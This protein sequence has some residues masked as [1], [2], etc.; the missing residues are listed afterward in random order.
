MSKTNEFDSEYSNVKY[1]EADNI[2]LITW[3][4]FC[5]FDNYRKPTTFALELLKQYENSNLVVDARHGFED[6]EEDVE[7]GFSFLLPQMSKTSC[8]KIAFIMEEINDIEGE[9]DMWTKEFGKYFA[10]FNANTYE[11]AIDKMKTMILVDVVY[12]IK[13]GK[14]K[15]FYE[16][17]VEM[18]IA[19][20][21]RQEPGCGRYEYSIPLDNENEL[22][23][24]ELWTDKIAQERHAK[25]QHFLKL[26][27]LKK[28]YVESV[29]L[30]K[31][32][33]N[34]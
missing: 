2:V 3:K 23:L 24:T 28:E 26:Q 18:G 21:S 12:V 4:K 10:V 19:K 29:R 9:M 34:E 15:E 33:I 6:D 20:A 8:K 5:C 30:T 13:D 16:K 25:T 17:I 7:W 11:A 22:W 14:R 27:E 32:Q 1:M 31:Y